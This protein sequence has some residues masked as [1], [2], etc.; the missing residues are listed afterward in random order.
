MAYNSDLF[1][2]CYVTE[3]SGIQRA[4]IL[5]LGGG[6]VSMVLGILF[7]VIEFTTV[8]INT[9]DVSLFVLSE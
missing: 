3:L 7:L 1:G 4:C 8:F 9:K 5:D 2:L 6:V